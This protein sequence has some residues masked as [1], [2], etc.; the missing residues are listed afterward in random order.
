MSVG[1]RINAWVGGIGCAALLSTG[2]WLQGA[3]SVADVHA[4]APPPTPAIR[5]LSERMGCQQW[6]PGYS[7]AVTIIAT[8]DASGALTQIQ[9]IRVKERGRAKAM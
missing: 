5:P 6:A 7:R 4:E 8:E 2:A 9:C 3:A 1:D